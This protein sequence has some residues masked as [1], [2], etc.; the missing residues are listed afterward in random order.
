MKIGMIVATD[1]A[2]VRLSDREFR[3]L[4]LGEL[5]RRQVWI[6]L[7]T[8]QTFLTR[9]SLLDDKIVFSRR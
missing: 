6:D 7:F 9:G 3:G 2:F 5:Y 8:I 4:T 1:V